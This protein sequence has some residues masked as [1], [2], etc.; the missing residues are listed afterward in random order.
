VSLHARWV[1]VPLVVGGASA[2]CSAILGLDP[3][4]S[5]ADGGGVSG[6]VTTEL[7]DGSREASVP[8]DSMAPDAASV[9]PVCAPLGAVVADAATTY[10][11][12]S[13]ADAGAP[14]WE[15]FDTSRL[16]RRSA[17]T[18]GTFDGRYVYLAG[19]GTSVTRF[20]TSGRFADLTSWSQFDLAALGISGGFGGAVFDGRYVYYV[21]YLTSTTHPS[22]VA[23]FDTTASF[24]ASSSWAWFDVSTLPVDGG[25]AAGGFF[26]AGFDG[27]YIYFVPHDD[28]VFDGR[29]VRY[30]TTPVDGG[31][32]ADAGTSGAGDGGDGGDS[33][34]SS[35]SIAF[36]N[37][38]LW[39]TYDVSA[40]NPAA[41]GFAGAVF[42]GTSLYL[43]PATN[44][45]FDSAVHGGTSGVVA[46][47]RTDAGFTAPSSWSTFDMTVVNGLAENFLGGAFDGRYVYFAPRG[48]GVVSRL[49]TAAG[50]FGTVSAWSTYDPTRLFAATASMPQYAGA[51]FDGR[52]VYFVP[53]GGGF[54]SL[55]R[56][57]TLST[58]TADC[59]WSTFDLT[60]IATGDAGAPLYVG[61]IFDGQYL[62]VVPDSISPIVRFK[63]KTP[64]ALPALPAF[65]GSF[66]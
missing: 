38:T 23:R 22:V 20:D 46:R 59:A 34:P 37:T 66:L 45:V 32:P 63:A 3:P 60:Q 41:V 9:P 42:D 51:A 64:Q 10:S 28:G 47:F 36:S 62:Y 44:D 65:H 31:S 8:L 25:A 57:D 11:P 52:F 49:D 13:Q 4:P 12:L 15:A 2:A 58:F 35:G 40:T 48:G 55:T 61:A 1:M 33:G 7:E 21:P 54:D 30:D 24:S 19:R 53:A 26:G 17:Y 18:G 43:V 5:A 39:Q 16:A 56:Y 14:A 6:D 29:V 27:R 50:A